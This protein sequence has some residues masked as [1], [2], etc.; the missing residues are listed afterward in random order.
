[1]YA[2]YSPSIG[3][4]I[5]HVQPAWRYVPVLWQ[6]PTDHTLGPY[7]TLIRRSIGPA[8]PMQRQTEHKRTNGR[9]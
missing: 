5:L 3:T 7:A 4:G 8:A 6:R 2:L 1:M 9:Y